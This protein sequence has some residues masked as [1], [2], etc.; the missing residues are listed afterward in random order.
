MDGKPIKYRRREG[1]KKQEEK[2]GKTHFAF[3]WT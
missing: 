3:N 2:E 1:Q